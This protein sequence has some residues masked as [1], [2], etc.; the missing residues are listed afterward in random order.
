MGHDEG[1]AQLRAEFDSV[2]MS[3]LVMIDRDDGTL[4]SAYEFHANLS[5][6]IRTSWV[7]ISRIKRPLFL[8]A[9]WSLRVPFL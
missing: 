1:L 7:L 9:E 6:Y 4:G 2:A 5:V 8:R 3:S